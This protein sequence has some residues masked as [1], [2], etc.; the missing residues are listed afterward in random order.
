MRSRPRARL[1][2][3]HRASWFHR[4]L[5]CRREMRG[6]TKRRAKLIRS[7]PRRAAHRHHSG[8]RGRPEAPF[9]ACVVRSVKIWL[10]RSRSWH[11]RRL[12][13]AVSS[14]SCCKPRSVVSGSGLVRSRARSVRLPPEPASSCSAEAVLRGRMVRVERR[15]LSRPRDLVA[16]LAIANARPKREAWRGRVFS[17]LIL[18]GNRIRARAR[19]RVPHLRLKTAAHGPLRTAFDIAERCDQ[20]RR[21]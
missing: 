21:P 1:R 11:W 7:R 2:L 4:V 9:W 6:A 12:R 16:E 3:S 19:G 18:A 20:R 13:T 10:V 17:R 5:R 15:V 8:P 14:S